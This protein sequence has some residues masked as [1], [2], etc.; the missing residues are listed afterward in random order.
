L[1]ELARAVTIAMNLHHGQ[2][3]KNGEPYIFHPLRVMALVR[4]F[5]EDVVCAAVLHDVVEDGGIDVESLSSVYEFNE[6]VT[7]AVD[8]LTRRKGERY[9]DYI[10]RCR[11]NH[12]AKTV[13]QADLQDN[14]RVSNDPKHSERQKRYLAAKERLF[15]S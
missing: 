2:V 8:A 11:N 12:I 13:K 7:S 14:S 6:A 15:S 4:D 9:M 5:D 10:D 3:D 1:S